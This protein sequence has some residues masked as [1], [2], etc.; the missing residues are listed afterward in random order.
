M[1]QE[2]EDIYQNYRQTIE[3]P[4]QERRKQWLDYLSQKD[5]AG[6]PVSY[7]GVETPTSTSYGANVQFSQIMR[8]VKTSY[9]SGI[10][11][12]QFLDQVSSRLQDYTIGL[13]EDKKI[14]T[15]IQASELLTLFQDKESVKFFLD[16]YELPLNVEPKGKGISG[17]SGPKKIE[18]TYG[19]GTLIIE[20]GAPQYEGGFGP[21]GRQKLKETFDQTISLAISRSIELL[22]N[23]VDYD[24]SRKGGANL[25]KR[26]QGDKEIKEALSYDTYSI[27]WDSFEAFYKKE[28]N[29]GQTPMKPD[30]IKEVNRALEELL[31]NTQS[32]CAQKVME[33]RKEIKDQS[34]ERPKFEDGPQ[35]GGM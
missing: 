30:Q 35:M 29:D 1:T 10:K 16:N 15:D 9:D 12:D 11:N 33:S 24:R 3:A 21:L 23:A 31:I 26:L 13:H 6:I 17:E 19:R 8:D 27:V 14:L 4:S 34:K 28:T 22:G 18:P 5:V 20:G 7:F 2:L 32:F 25:L